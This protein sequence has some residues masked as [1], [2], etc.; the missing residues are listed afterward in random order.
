MI[1]FFS[2]SAPERFKGSVIAV[3]NLLITEFIF[4]LVVTM[5]RAVYKVIRRLCC[6]KCEHFEVT[7]IDYIDSFERP[8]H[9]FFSSY[10][11]KKYFGN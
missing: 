7:V 6:C 10:I 8:S 2:S 4:L 1:L 5:P 3:K 9:Q 11:I